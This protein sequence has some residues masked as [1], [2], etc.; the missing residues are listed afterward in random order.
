MAKTSDKPQT[1]EESM[2]NLEKIVQ[3]VESGQIGLE[4]SL[5][6]FEQGMQLIKRCRQM[7]DSAEKRIEVL[8]Q[9]GDNL[10]AKPL[11]A[12]ALRQAAAGG[13]ASADAP[14]DG[15]GDS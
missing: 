2:A 7:L 10:T 9:E 15:N 14:P 3:A 6:R 5:A 12:E 11:D 4:E 8:S 13:A 1:F